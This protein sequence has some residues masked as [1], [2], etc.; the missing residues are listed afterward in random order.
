MFYAERAEFFVESTFKND[1]KL[2]CPLT[3]ETIHYECFIMNK[4]SN[5]FI[6]NHIGVCFQKIRLSVL[7]YMHPKRTVNYQKAIIGQIYSECN[8]LENT[9]FRYKFP[10]MFSFDNN[11]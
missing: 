5:F 11:T 3:S 4:K 10:V 7:Y 6:C 9:L 8:M 2:E 1:W